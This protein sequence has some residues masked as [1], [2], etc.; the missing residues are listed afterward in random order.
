MK[1]KKKTFRQTGRVPSLSDPFNP[2]TPSLI[3]LPL[4]IIPG[5]KQSMYS[6]C[7]S[8]TFHVNDVDK[9]LELL[10]ARC[11]NNFG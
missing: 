6:A 1:K 10:E 2:T 9:F 3:Q 11:F 5:P 8:C 7:E 4:L